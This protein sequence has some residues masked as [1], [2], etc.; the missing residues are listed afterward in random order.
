MYPAS[1]ANMGYLEACMRAMI[2][3]ATTPLFLR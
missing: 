2:D 1:G 3:G